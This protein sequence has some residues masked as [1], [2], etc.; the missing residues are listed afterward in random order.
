MIKLE[1]DKAYLI[2][3]MS[4]WISQG[5]IEDCNGDDTYKLISGKEAK[6]KPNDSHNP[7]VD[8]FMKV[9]RKISKF[10]MPL[11]PCLSMSEEM[12][13]CKFIGLTL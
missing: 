4:F 8:I 10:M 7:I 1:M 3:K 11:L 5:V 13:K 12:Q 2:Q 9:Q 6:G